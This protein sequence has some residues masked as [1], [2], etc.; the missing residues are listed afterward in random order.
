MAPRGPLP[1]R[2]Y[3]VRRTIVLVVALALVFGVA[4]VL[5]SF[6]GD[7]GSGATATTASQKTTGSPSAS[8]SAPAL[9]ASAP[10]GQP[11][12][13]PQVS[14]PADPGLSQPEGTCDDADITVAPTT[15]AVTGGSSVVLAMRVTTSSAKACTWTVSP[16]SLVLKVTSG[17]DRVWSSQD[18]PASVP[19]QAIAVRPTN[20]TAT[21]VTVT[22]SGK[23]S[24]GG[25]PAGTA[26]ADP[27]F[28]HVT[29]ASLGGEPTD[30]QFELTAPPQATVTKTAKPKNKKGK[31]KAGQAATN[32]AG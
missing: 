2:V 24:S 4:Q 6:G 9:T 18:C 30:V 14:Q 28:Y 1:A 10:S 31:K 25:C 20:E 32:P 5:R 7:D 11:S 12:V 23:R 21:E 16:K 8:T 13:V 26:W 17:K 29:A 3:W 19:S 22:W 15:K 27:G